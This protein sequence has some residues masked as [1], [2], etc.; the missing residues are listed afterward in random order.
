MPFF[1]VGN[2]SQRILWAVLDS[3]PKKELAM[4]NF[5]LLF[6]IGIFLTGCGGGSNVITG[7]FND[8]LGEYRAYLVGSG[9]IINY[10][11]GYE[12]NTHPDYQ[13]NFRL[14]KDGV[15]FE[16]SEDIT[17]FKIEKYSYD[18]V[19]LYIETSG[20]VEVE[21]LGLSEMVDKWT[22]SITPGATGGTISTEYH[23]EGIEHN[24]F[25]AG[26][27]LGTVQKII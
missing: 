6:S 11:T 21:N 3:A 14:Y 5:L 26:T 9:R 20:V 13:Q 10:D 22:I 16:G 8:I 1:T 25:N 18:G 15:A 24:G 7:D 17:D 12:R 27:T 23:A 4:R 19:I 2:L